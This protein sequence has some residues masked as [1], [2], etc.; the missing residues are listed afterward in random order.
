ML[1]SIFDNP[2]VFIHQI[3]IFFL[4]TH[5]FLYVEQRTIE[6]HYVFPGHRSQ[7]QRFLQFFFGTLGVFQR[8]GDDKG[9]FFLNVFPDC[10]LVPFFGLLDQFKHQRFVGSDG[11]HH[12][13]EQMWSSHIDGFTLLLQRFFLTLR[14]LQLI[15]FVFE[16]KCSSYIVLLVFC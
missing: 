8:L 7:P 13:I 9:A 14:F 11:F 16:L 10:C 12:F 2:I 6:I 3:F 15:S 4:E 5:R 1:W